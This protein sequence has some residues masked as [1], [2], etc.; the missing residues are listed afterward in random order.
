MLP[1]E[2]PERRLSDAK[3]ACGDSLHR[4][5]AEPLAPLFLR[6]GDGGTLPRHRRSCLALFGIDTTVRARGRIEEELPDIV[7]VPASALADC[8][9]TCGTL[10]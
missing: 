3:C 4:E 9:A 2:R 8:A 10:P 7:L 6:N 1:R 5:D